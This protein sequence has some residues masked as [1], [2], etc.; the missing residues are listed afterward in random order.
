MRVQF[1]KSKLLEN[2]P[3]HV[4]CLFLPHEGEENLHQRKVAKCLLLGMSIETD[5]RFLVS[6]DYH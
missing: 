6:F 4:Q 5:C 1:C 3:V 2:Q